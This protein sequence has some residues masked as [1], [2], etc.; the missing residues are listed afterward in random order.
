MRLKPF[1][2]YYGSKFRIIPKYP[3]P[4]F[5]TIVEAFA[6]SA[7]YGCAHWNRKVI[8]IDKN[9]I[10]VG[11]W[12]FLIRAPEREILALPIDINHVDELVGVPEE[13]K[14]LVGFWFCT[15]HVSPLRARN[16]RHRWMVEESGEPARFA[17]WHEKIRARIASQQE[18]IRHWKVKCGDATKITS[19]VPA[20]WFVDPP[21]IGPRGA[22]YPESDIDY[23]KLGEW[24]L[25]RNGQIIVCENHGATWLPFRPFVTTTAAWGKRQS[26]EAI[27][28]RST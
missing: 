26:Q 9:P 21:Y 7:A 23:T 19:E 17:T 2:S 5:P 10:I 25:G 13:A 18:C 14:W 27:Y 15:A 24:C 6:G 12:D 28:T 8:L 20:T 4:M 1:F 16:T 22:H 11:V 3:R